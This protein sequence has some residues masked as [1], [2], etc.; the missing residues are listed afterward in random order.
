MKKKI[1]I[2]QLFTRLFGNSNNANIPDG[3]IEENG[4]GKFNDITD[5]V[6]NNLKKAGYT[7]I[8]YIGVL[9]HA[10]ATDYEKLGVPRQ[11]PEIVKGKAGSPYAVRDYYNV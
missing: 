4:S 6:L 9:A 5:K 11:F 8:W 3:S 10:S 7:H 2:Y 1:F